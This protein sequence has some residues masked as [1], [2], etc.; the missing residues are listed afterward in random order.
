MNIL[1]AGVLC[2]CRVRLCGSVQR[3]LRNISLHLIKRSQYVR[4]QVRTNSNTQQG[5][6]DNFLLVVS[7]EHSSRTVLYKPPYFYMFCF[8]IAT[9]RFSSW[10]SN[11]SSLLGTLGRFPQL[12]SEP[13][14]TLPVTVGLLRSGTT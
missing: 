9:T 14:V 3:F 2:W 11:D 5:P 13:R 1:V 4:T 7:T 6:K 12:I 8:D 10:P